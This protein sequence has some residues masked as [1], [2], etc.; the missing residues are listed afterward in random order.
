MVKICTN[1]DRPCIRMEIGGN[2]DELVRRPD[3]PFETLRGTRVALDNGDLYEK[4]EEETL[5]DKH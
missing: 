3:F 5:L 4:W 1:A 2:K